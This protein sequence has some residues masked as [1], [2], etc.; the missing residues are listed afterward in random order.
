MTIRA[1]RRSVA[2]L[3]LLLTSHFC[4]PTSDFSPAAAPQSPPQRIVSLVPAV[5]EMLFAMGAGPAVVGVSSYD[6]YPPEAA[7]RPRVGALIDPDVERILSLRPDL[8]I[9]YGSQDD[10]QVQLRRA[11]IATFDYRHAGLA[12]IT[13]TIREIGVRVGR[14]PESER[15]ALSI[16]REIGVIRAAVAGR[17][18]PRT[19]LIFGREI[20]SLRG[21]YASAGV[22]FM[23][24]MLLVAGGD[25]VFGDVKQQSLQTSVELLIA[26]APEVIIETHPA[27]GWTPERIAA[28]VKLWD[29][30]T[31]IPAVRQK[32]VHIIGDDRL[33]IPGPRVAL[34]IRVLA[35]VLHPEVRR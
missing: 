32:R 10:L 1:L 15:V 12:D 21:I 23:H 3:V 11:G 29:R 24:D 33:S 27:A 19:A 4:L 16:E 9:V 2:V 22:G 7:T 17:R 14:Q 18:R 31:T 28:D 30:L 6:R 26:R 20:G 13:T 34:A 35:E 8:V 5:T 25:D